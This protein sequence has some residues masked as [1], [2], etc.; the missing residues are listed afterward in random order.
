MLGQDA[1]D[2]G[3]VCTTPCILVFGGPDD[4]VVEASDAVE[5]EGDMLR[6][7]TLDDQGVPTFDRAVVVQEVLS[8]VPSVIDS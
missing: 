5:T 1:R 6:F 2:L 7:T 8:F 4:D 3:D